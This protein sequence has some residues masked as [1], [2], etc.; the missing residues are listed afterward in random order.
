[1]IA[2]G[3]K[4]FMAELYDPSTGT[5]TAT[6]N[7]TTARS[8]HTA[9]LLPNGRVLIA[10]GQE[11]NSSADLH[12]AEL[13]DP[14]SGTFTYTGDMNRGRTG[15]SAN[16][17]PNGKVLITGGFVKW[18]TLADAELYDPATGTFAVTGDY[19]GGGTVCDFCPPATL[20][21][22]GMVLFPAVQPAQLYDPVAGAFN[23][24][25]AMIFN[26][27][28]TATLLRND[29]VLLTGGESDSVG[30]AA[31][32][33]LYDPSTGTF[34][35]TSN[36]TSRR[37]WHSATLLPDGTVLIAGGET[38]SCTG[39]FCMFAG[40]VASVELYDS[41]TGAFAPAG[42]MTTPRETHTATLLAD[43]RVLI[44]GGVYYGGIGLFYGSLASAELYSPASAR[45]SGANSTF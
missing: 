11:P 8:G 31:L 3:T 18:P 25:G 7:M 4:S 17:L 10:G 28:T 2:G 20:L 12:T 37:A 14:D 15:H 1:L 19:I 41:T 23:V 27:H 36:M 45:T 33:E 39:N 40:T 21:S 16:L 29:K 6:G 42:N 24:I 9:T 30:R 26:A 5:F 13:Y 44:T 32:A 43:G 22:D 34:S 38:D 35:S